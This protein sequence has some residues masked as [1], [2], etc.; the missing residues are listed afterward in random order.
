MVSIFRLKAVPRTFI[1]NKK[2]KRKYFLDKLSDSSTFTIHNYRTTSTT[3][4]YPTFIDSAYGYALII[5]FVLRKAGI[6]KAEKRNRKVP[7]WLRPKNKWKNACDVALGREKKKENSENQKPISSSDYP[8]RR[9]CVPELKS[10]G[11]KKKTAKLKVV[12]FSPAF[13]FVS[14][15]S[16]TAN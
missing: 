7:A 11:D 14:P 2:G 16:L 1:S 9:Q 13:V 15:G 6:I 3:S 12:H 10:E 5:F 4:I 8:H